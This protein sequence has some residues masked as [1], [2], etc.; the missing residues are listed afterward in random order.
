MKY[1][2]LFI[3]AI[4]LCGC[5][6]SKSTDQVLSDASATLVRASRAIDEEREWARNQ[7]HEMWM[8]VGA[9]MQRMGTNEVTFSASELNQSNL[10]IMWEQDGLATN[11]PK[12]FR[13]GTNYP[14]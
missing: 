12:T 6:Q 7:N 1:L 4:A 13:F 8:L 11:G 10:W 2:T 3:L 14:R 5:S 9:L